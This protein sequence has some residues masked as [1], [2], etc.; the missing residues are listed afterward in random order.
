LREVV[1]RDE[2]KFVTQV[3]IHTKAMVR[4]FPSPACPLTIIIAITN[5]STNF[6]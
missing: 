1:G 2:E 3:T 6:H 5:Y 4:R